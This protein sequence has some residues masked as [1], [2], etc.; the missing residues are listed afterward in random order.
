MNIPAVQLS[1][2]NAVRIDVENIDKQKSGTRK[3]VNDQISRINQT[4]NSN[5][6]LSAKKL[7]E[8]PQK[9]K[10][11]KRIEEVAEKPQYQSLRLELAKKL[12]DID[13]VD[14][15][16][17]D[18]DSIIKPKL[19]TPAEQHAF[20][21]WMVGI[22]Y[23]LGS[24][25]YDHNLFFKHMS[26][27]GIK[28]F[29]SPQFKK[30]FAHFARA[31]K[32]HAHPLKKTLR[33]A[34]KVKN[35]AIM[36]PGSGGGG[37]KSPATAMAKDLEARGYNV[38]LLDIDEFEKPYDPK[39]GG[40]T[41]GDIYTKIY[42]QQGNPELAYKMWNEGNDLQPIKDRRYMKDLTDTLRDFKTDHLFV[43]AHHEPEHTSLAYQ[44]GIP[45]TYVNTDNEFH[46][47]L[48]DVAL[49]QQEIKKPLV[50]FIALN[51]QSEFYHHL[52]HHEGKGHYNEL[53][54]NVRKQM[55]RMNFPVRENFK[56]VTRAEKMQVRKELGIAEDALVVKL[57]MGAN[58]IPD[59][60]KLI[61]NNIKQE[62]HLAHKPLHLLVVCGSNKDLKAELDQMKGEFGS[63]P[64]F[65]MDVLGFLNEKE[66]SDYDKASDVWVTKPGGSTAAEAHAMKKQMLY[67]SNPHHQWELTNAK[68]LERE[69]LAEELHLGGSIM[70]QINRR[71]A[72]GQELEHFQRNEEK[73]M[74]QLA[75]VV[76]KKA[77]P[78]L[79]VA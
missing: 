19:S 59:D 30:T 75:M 63:D 70:D 22:S 42:Q 48:Q 8:M 4:D 29:S 28:T 20:E 35:I 64:R 43:V 47:H 53:P 45:A 68:V 61:M 21:Q 6:D 1:N 44:L 9:S 31:I 7:R 37:H 3:K 12:N 32:S 76:E 62:A 16:L 58:G 24:P 41:R 77:L 26:A 46:A 36:Y 49:N 5:L 51:D 65:K 11:Q 72:I 25:S 10:L 18:Y 33:T 17:Y 50:G 14:K 2:N 57:A 40:L 34:H 38:K 52:L 73:W 13:R 71:A 79:E 60:I 67:L 56:Q 15:I 69:N 66:M 54:K 39:V 55:V 27:S 23:F 78:I 74:D